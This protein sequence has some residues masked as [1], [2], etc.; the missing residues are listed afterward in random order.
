[1]ERLDRFPALRDEGD[2]RG[3]RRRYLTGRDD[4]EVV[5][6]G[7]PVGGAPDVA[8][9]EPGEAERGQYRVIEPGAGR[10][11]ADHEHDVVDDD[12]TLDHQG[13]T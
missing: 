5:D 13:G 3:R 1:M 7:Y 8:G 4:R 6:S 10:Q 11:V 12:A 2:V 9:T